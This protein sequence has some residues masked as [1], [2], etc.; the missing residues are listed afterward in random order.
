LSE[1]TD[2]TD[3][4]DGRTDGQA[5]AFHNA[6]LGML[7]SV[8]AVVDEDEDWA[9]GLLYL[10]LKPEFNPL[11]LNRFLTWDLSKWTARSD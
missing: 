6:N 4:T 10:S 3:V 5:L 1:F 2:V 9:T 11:V 8:I 7:S